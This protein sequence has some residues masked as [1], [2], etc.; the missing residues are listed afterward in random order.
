[1]DPCESNVGAAAPGVANLPDDNGVPLSTLN[2]FLNVAILSAASHAQDEGVSSQ[3]QCVSSQPASMALA[4][5]NTADTTAQGPHNSSDFVEPVVPALDATQRGATMEE[6]AGL[7]QHDVGAQEQVSTGGQG[8]DNPRSTKTSV[9]Q[10]TGVHPAACS[11]VAGPLVTSAELK[12]SGSNPPQLNRAVPEDVQRDN[13]KVSEEAPSRS[14]GQNVD[15]PNASESSRSDVAASAQP[16][17]CHSDSNVD[18]ATREAQSSGTHSSDKSA[19]VPETKKGNDPAE[20]ASIIDLSEPQGSN[21]YTNA[22]L[23]FCQFC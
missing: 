20:Q 5:A 1:M 12:E 6:V 8:D 7:T 16:A 9:M 2:S 23:C 13:V 15:A 22:S 17:M 14:Q 4:D 3:P 19:D 21:A 10:T 11:A 18:V